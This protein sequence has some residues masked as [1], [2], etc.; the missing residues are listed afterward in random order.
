MSIVVK[1]SSGTTRVVLEGRVSV[2][3]DLSIYVPAGAEVHGLRQN[4]R[5]VG[6]PDGFEDLTDLELDWTLKS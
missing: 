3:P 4:F 2:F 6:T 1:Y 5:R